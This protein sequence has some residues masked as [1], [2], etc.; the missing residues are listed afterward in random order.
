MCGGTI[1]VMKISVAVAWLL[2]SVSSSPSL[3]SA[4]TPQPQPQPEFVKQALQLVHDGKPQEALDVYLNELKTSP[5]SLPANLGAAGILDWMGKGKDAR[6]H[7]AKA[8]E[9]ADTPEHR[10]AAERSM[11]VSY[12][13]ERDCGKAI[14]Y[15]QQVF[16]F[17][18]S[19]KNFYQQGESADEGARICLDAGDLEAA[20]K[21]YRIG[22]DS[23]LQEP[24]IK[25]ARQDLWA[26]RLEN[27]EARIAA[28]R[29]DSSQAQKHVDAAKAILDKGTIPEQAQFLPSLRGYVAFY[30]KD[31]KA[32]LASFA[33][34][35]QNDPAIQCMIAESFEKLGEKDKAQASLSASHSPPAAYAVPLARKKLR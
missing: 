29:G 30:G 24:D 9:A 11:A 10:V 20:Q 3:L 18:A 31:Y 7:L 21:W 23:G 16:D 33:D 5:G 1:A 27:A 28:R 14:E 6:K 35:N 13:F 17:Y 25:P 4:Q 32:A 34:A 12:A 8:I 19:V 26:F 22:H 15:E 2:L